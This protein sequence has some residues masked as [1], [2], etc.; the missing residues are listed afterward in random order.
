MYNHRKS[1]F[2]LECIHAQLLSRV[3]LCDPWNVA[4]QASLFMRLSQQEYWSALP[5]PSP[6]DLPHSGVE[7]EPPKAPAL[8]GGL[9][10]TEPPRKPLQLE[11]KQWSHLRMPMLNS[12]M[13]G[14]IPVH[15]LTFS[16]AGTGIFCLGNKGRGGY[17]GK[18]QAQTSPSLLPTSCYLSNLRVNFSCPAHVSDSCLRKMT[19]YYSS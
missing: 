1:D 14:W 10:T 7:S 19:S 8:A 9:F 16:P 6:G 4:H 13:T 11:Y 12:L 5:F 2:Q 17:A 3:R 18:R 15:S